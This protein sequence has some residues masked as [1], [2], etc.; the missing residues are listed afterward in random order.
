MTLVKSYVIIAMSL[1]KGGVII[2]MNRFKAF[3][4]SNGL[5]QKDVA[6]AL[7]INQV[8]VW[9]WENGETMPRAK[10]LPAIADLFGCRIDELYEKREGVKNNDA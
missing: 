2:R 3:R 8:S 4:L 1:E 7:G 6:D 9:Q 10:L 5:T